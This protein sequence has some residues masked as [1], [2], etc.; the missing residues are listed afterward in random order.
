MKLWVIYRCNEGTDETLVTQGDKENPEGDL[1]LDKNGW[2]YYKVR[3]PYD[4]NVMTPGLNHEICQARSLKL[5][6]AGQQ[7]C[8]YNIANCVVTPL[9]PSSSTCNDPWHPMDK[10]ADQLCPGVGSYVMPWIQCPA[11]ER[12]IA[13]L[14]CDI[15]SMENG[16][17]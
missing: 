16:I 12:F 4:K 9:S 14:T 1:L 15:V 5:Q 7:G 3:V 2:S 17:T 6:C 10:L 11:L 13:E 8:Q